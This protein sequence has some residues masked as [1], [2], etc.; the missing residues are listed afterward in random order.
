MSLSI[1]FSY[2]CTAFS[3]A[4]AFCSS[5]CSE[6][7]DVK[8]FHVASSMLQVISPI[9]KQC[10]CNL[11]EVA[12]LQLVTGHLSTVSGAHL[13]PLEYGRQCNNRYKQSRRLW[14]DIFVL[15]SIMVKRPRSL[16]Y[17]GRQLPSGKFPLST[18]SSLH[19]PL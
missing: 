3:E 6:N 1:S 17:P 2:A 7:T 12:L 9:A 10:F 14:E 13:Q 18:T 16:F 15:N 5:I 19:F 4:C 8:V 11:L